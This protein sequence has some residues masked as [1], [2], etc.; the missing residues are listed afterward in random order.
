MVVE[1]RLIVALWH[2]NFTT[3]PVWTCTVRS[4]YYIHWSVL[5]RAIARPLSDDNKTL[6]VGIPV[7]G[8]AE[9]GVRNSLVD[10][11]ANQVFHTRFRPT[12]PI[13]LCST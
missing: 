1:H 11:Q 9:P 7:L 6:Q 13:S 2:V 4:K 12:L 5:V 3:L 8:Q 10:G